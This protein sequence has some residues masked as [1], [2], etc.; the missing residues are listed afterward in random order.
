MQQI[1]QQ[2]KTKL[3]HLIKASDHFEDSRGKLLA[4][5]PTLTEEETKTAVKEIFN[6][7]LKATTLHQELVDFITKYSNCLSEK[8]QLK[9]SQHFV[10]GYKSLRKYLNQ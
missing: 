9:I 6:V 8:Q 10:M 3:N 4:N 5:L 2:L 7:R 1:L